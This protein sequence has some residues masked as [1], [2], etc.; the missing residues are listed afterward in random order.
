MGSRGGSASA[1]NANRAKKANSEGFKLANRLKLANMITSQNKRR[2]KG[3]RNQ[4]A[5][6][7]KEQMA[8]LH[9]IS[10]NLSS[11]SLKRRQRSRTGWNLKAA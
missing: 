10:A 1:D 9:E 8:C 4:I 6:F 3:R 7:Y 2:K 11:S 5:F